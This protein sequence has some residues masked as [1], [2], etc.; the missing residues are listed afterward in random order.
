MYTYIRIIFIHPHLLIV[1]KDLR[2]NVEFCI[3][4][5]FFFGIPLLPPRANINATTW[6]LYQRKN[7]F[8]KIDLQIQLL[9]LNYFQ[10]H[11]ITWLLKQIID[12]N[13]LYYGKQAIASHIF[14]RNLPIVFIDGLSTLQTMYNENYQVNVIYVFIYVIYMT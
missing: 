13:F 12:K 9:L 8:Q 1:S 10:L 11:Y 14:G 7:D 4:A 6:G 5:K 2:S 3:S